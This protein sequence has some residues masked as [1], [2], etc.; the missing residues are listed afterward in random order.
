MEETLGALAGVAQEK[1]SPGPR[2]AD[3]PTPKQGQFLAYIRE[4]MLHNRTGLAPTHAVL[5]RAFDLTPPSVNSMLTRL[6]QRGFIRRTPGQA[7][8]I[9]LTIDPAW[10]PELDRTFKW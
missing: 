9:V 8:G 1:L 10:I 6:E 4:Y 3:L 5:Q 2:P 7:R